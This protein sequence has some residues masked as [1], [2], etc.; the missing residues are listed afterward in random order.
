MRDKKFSLVDGLN[1]IFLAIVFVFFLFSLP[2]NP[3]LVQPFLVLALSGVLVFYAIYLRKKGTRNKVE[4]LFLL[5]YPL[6]FLFMIFESFFMILPYF[7]PNDYDAQLTQIDFSMLG[8]HPT[9]WIEQWVHP[10]LT[11]LMYLLYLFYFPLP[12]FILGYL[13]K[14]G[15]YRNLDKSVFLLFLVYF[16][17]YIGY[18][19]IPAMG[20]RF[21]ES[22]MALQTKNL[23]GLIFAAPIRTLIGYFEPNKFDAFPSLHM[24]I[25]LCTLLLMGKF[26]PKMFWIFLPVVIGIW[27]SLVYCRYH[28][29]ID[30]IVGA[31]WTFVAFYGGNALYNRLAKYNFAPYYK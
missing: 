3:Y 23:D 14:K 9:V 30:I 20:P 28:Y 13:Y 6:F 22:L 7:N 4:D 17:A 29:V 25:S 10:W 5:F 21:N 24:G 1:L 2:G 26:K 18:F 11:D 27:I 19:A 12:L 31:A 15:D 16:G 8:V